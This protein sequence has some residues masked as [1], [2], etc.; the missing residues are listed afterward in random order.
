MKE[1]E[2]LEEIVN[3]NKNRANQ[4][5]DEFSDLDA[6]SN[7]A[8]ALSKSKPNKKSFLQTSLQ[9]NSVQADTP[10]Q[11]VYNLC[12]EIYKEVSQLDKQQEQVRKTTQPKKGYDEISAL[13]TQNSAN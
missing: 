11:D 10:N 7:N 2:L 3:K 13:V 6:Q 9:E 8:S 5:L 12:D 4:F 1:D